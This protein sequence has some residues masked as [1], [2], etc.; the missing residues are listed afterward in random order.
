M[1]EDVTLISCLP[2]DSKVVIATSSIN[3]KYEGTWLLGVMPS[4]EKPNDDLDECQ[5]KCTWLD[6]LVKLTH[7]SHATRRNVHTTYLSLFKDV[8]VVDR[9]S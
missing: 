3:P 4:E 1:L 5:V 8:K 7:P 9:L 6:N 2:I